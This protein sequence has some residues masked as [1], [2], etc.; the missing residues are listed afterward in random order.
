MKSTP[1]GLLALISGFLLTGYAQDAS[2]PSAPKKKW[3][4]ALSNAY[5]G[6]I[7]RH[8]M[9]DAFR[10]AA[11]QAKSE[12]LISEY[13]IENADGTAGQQ[14]AQMSSLI[15]KGVDAIA[16]N[17]ASPTALNG[18]IDKACQAGIKILAF[19]SIATADCAYKFDFDM[20][21]IFGGMADYIAGKLMNGKG[22]VLL[23]R[24]VQGSAPDKI[25]SDAQ[26]DVLKK[27]PDIKVVGEIYGQAT[28][29]VAQS[30]VA[31]I[32]PTL[33]NV[34]AVIA[35]GGGD[36]IGIVQAFEQ[37]G[38][39]L[40][41]IQGG[42]TSNFLKWW[43]EQNQ[44]APYKTVSANTA[45]G[46]GGAAVWLTIAI[47]NGEKVPKVIKMPGASVTAENLNDYASM[48]PG[49]IVSPTYSKDWVEKN[50]V[51]K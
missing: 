2:Q 48:P 13:F 20:V 25:I 21:G 34:D 45:P 40:P 26:K 28:T 10:E 39:K 3:K 5:Y 12:G 31:G 33:K 44:K 17:A 18:V 47:L 42:G 43:A 32:L 23:V 22:D 14:N 1:L 30:A 49:Q 35:Q 46:I 15:L 27:Y 41:I 51:Q 7:W 9:V 16:I 11:E 38:R 6:N 8:Q 29:A 36:D 19:D 24:G 50:L 4:I 37:S